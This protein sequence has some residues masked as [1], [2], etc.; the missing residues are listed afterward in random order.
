MGVCPYY[1]YQQFNFCQEQRFEPS[2]F[3]LD[4]DL[5]SSDLKK[6]FFDLEQGIFIF[7]A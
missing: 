4:M 1:S 3:S 2:I 6:I 7:L 5:T